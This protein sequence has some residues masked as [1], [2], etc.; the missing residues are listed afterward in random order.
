LYTALWMWDGMGWD[1]M[2]SGSGVEDTPAELE[3]R[4]KH[5]M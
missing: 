4:D 3:S 5:V 1:G 2:V